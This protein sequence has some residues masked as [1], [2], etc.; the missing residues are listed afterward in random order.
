MSKK[1]LAKLL[2]FC[3]VFTMM[4][5]STF[6]ADTKA[7]NE[8]VYTINADVE[9][10]SVA[11][12]GIATITLGDTYTVG[13]DTTAVSTSK[14]VGTPSVEWI[15]KAGS[16]GEATVKG[17][18]ITAVKAGEVIL[19]GTVTV[20]N[21][22]AGTTV[23]V[24][25]VT[26]TITE[27]EPGTYNVNVA[28]ATNGTV[29]SD[30]TTA[31]EGD[32]VTLTVTP[33]TGYKVYEVTVLPIIETPAGGDFAAIT[34]TPG[35][36]GTYTFTMPA[37]DVTVTAIFVKD[38]GTVVADGYTVTINGNGVSLMTVG[39]K[40]TLTAVLREIKN[41]EETIKDINEI[42]SD[43]ELTWTTDVKDVVTISTSGRNCT[44]TANTVE[45]VQDV[46]IS[47]TLSVPKKEIVKD[48][49]GKETVKVV[50]DE[51]GNVVKQ[52]L[53]V[54][55]FKLTVTP[56][57]Y[58]IAMKENTPVE[59]FVNGTDA[60][61]TKALAVVVK[62]DDKEVTNQPVTW[63][64][65]DEKVA[66][67]DANGKVSAVGYGSA[68][69]TATLTGT[70]V[71][72]TR[73]VKVAYKPVTVTFNAGEG[74][75]AD[76]V[77]DKDGVVKATTNAQGKLTTFPNEP[78]REKYLFMGWVV[79]EENE[80]VTLDNV[81]AKDTTLNALWI[82]IK[83]LEAEVGATDET[84][85]QSASISGTFNA[86]ASNDENVAEGSEDSI[87]AAT[88]SKVTFDVTTKGGNTANTKEVT[89]YIAA[90]TAATLK[91]TN[92][93]EVITNVATITLSGEALQD[94]SK[95]GYNA[96]TNDVV[97][98]AEKKDTNSVTNPAI[99]N[100]IK[101]AYDFSM[102]LNGSNVINSANAKIN[103]S[104]KAPVGI[105]NA[106]Y[107]YFVTSTTALE[108]V[109]AKLDAGVITLSTSHFSEYVVSAD[110]LVY[111]I[112]FKPGTGTGAEYVQNVQITPNDKDG[113]KVPTKENL[114]PNQ[115]T[116]SGATFAYW[117]PGNYKNG[118][119]IEV[120]DDMTL[121]AV[122]KDDN[123]GNVI[124]SGSG[125]GGGSSSNVS[126][127]TKVTG[128][129]VTVTPT[130]PTR[131]QTVTITVAPAEGYKL[132]T[133]T[134]TDLKGNTIE[135]TKVSDTKY[136]FVMP[137]GK[138]KI[139]PSF[140]KVDGSDK[141]DDTTNVNKRF[142]DVD[143]NAWYAEYINYVA[144]NGLMNGYENGTFGPNDKTTRAQIVT[145]LFRMEGEPAVS[146]SSK[147]SDVS[148]GGQYYSSAVTWAA[149]NNIVNGYEDGRFGPNDNVTREQIA[150]ILFRYAEYKGY[151]TSLTGNVA[152]FNDAAKVSSWATNAIS[153]AIGEGLM[154]GD[155]G[156]L[157]PQGNATRAEIAALLMRFS[158]NIA[159]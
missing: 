132:D 50:K 97:L 22:P 131:G 146:A 51:K 35:A 23:K 148:A 111:T 49:N 43:A 61:V 135:L 117:T 139:T 144:E 7:A 116:K 159:K 33:A 105:T 152:S 91:N 55:T 141:K 127:A 65:S 155:N 60:E 64:S 8:Y 129:K 134:V 34:V 99:A 10:N 94:L 100:K 9:P 102:K 87:P 48:E 63:T 122:W 110:K 72:A 88:T 45:K 5:F 36:N 57:K 1:F 118:Q 119:E 93:V 52:V 28:A 154:N 98:K 75:F 77:A 151:D 41:G 109:D 136:T 101:A 71:K 59:L 153:W 73:T 42:A 112:T 17:N 133:L 92:T 150:A 27:R 56:V 147:F 18:T 78:T 90:E 25:D 156:A 84:G 113:N 70:D 37:N 123:S 82:E 16:T 137:A 142:S 66:T 80:P 46:V 125:G 121:T 67:V 106:V 12:D 124:S 38:D 29:T 26:L 58:T 76:G 145:V 115:F 120:S 114:L 69:I 81:Y 104:F 79:G 20:P 83:P 24:K 21:L 140:V 143:A 96:G 54:G 4:P 128:G 85:K 31:K 44:V 15:V 30:K 47:A 53:A 6:A 3:M 14:L 62:A 2:I 149:R 19:S 158:E 68:T 86:A 126:I 103:V 138:V 40:N 11:V 89:V 107:A 13:T 39:S 157:R 108:P 130:R 32:T 95:A 74:K